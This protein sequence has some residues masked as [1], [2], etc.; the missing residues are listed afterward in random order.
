MTKP[1]LFSFHNEFDDVDVTLED[2]S[3]DSSGPFI[4]EWSCGAPEICSA[5]AP[6]RF[7]FKTLKE[8]H[9][10]FIELVNNEIAAV[11]DDGSFDS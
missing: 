3:F 9:A 1:A 5:D 2:E 10:K 8:A 4:V 11:L 6:E 7:E